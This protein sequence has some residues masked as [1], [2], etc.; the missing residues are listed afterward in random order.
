NRE[1][2]NEPE[3]SRPQNDPAGENP[4]YDPNPQGGSQPVR[5]SPEFGQTPGPG[6]PPE[7]ANEFANAGAYNPYR[8][9]PAPEPYLPVPDENRGKSVKAFTIAAWLIITALTVFLFSTTVYEQFNPTSSV[10]DASAGDL[11]QINLQG[12]MMV[13]QNALAPPAVLPP[14]LNTG[15][16]EARWCFSILQGEFVDP[17]SALDQLEE[18]D[19]LIRE[20]E[21]E[22]TDDQKRLRTLIGEVIESH[23]AGDFAA[24]YLA[25]DDQQFLKER[26]G[27]CGRLLLYP[28]G[29]E[30]TA[31][32]AQLVGEAQFALIVM[33]LVVLGG[34]A[35][36]IAGIIVSI[37][38]LVR[39]SSGT[40]YRFFE[41]P[42]SNGGVY[43][44][45]FA[46][47]MVIFICGQLGAALLLTDVV[48]EVGMMFVM[49]GVF[50]ASL[51]ALAW[52]VIR[53]IPFSR[54]R[55]DIGWEL[56]NP[57]VEAVLGAISY[58]S[59][60]P[61]M[62]VGLILA[63]VIMG[64]VAAA[65]GDGGGDLS[66]AGAQG[67]PIQEQIAQGNPL[68]FL[69]VFLTA[70]VAA[71]IVEETMFRGVL[72]RHMR[73]S[74]WKWG[75]GMTVMASAL[76]SSLIFAAI[77]PQGLFGI[78]ILT[79]LAF[80]FCLV[81]EWRDSLIGPMVMHAINNSIVTCLLFSIM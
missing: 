50:F 19:E 29:S 9:E 54:V 67:H 25:D 34:G 80:G 15:P 27:Y 77:H 21:Y 1:P 62:F 6:F 48:P 42:R 4:S 3:G 74:S 8:S 72:Y 37:V 63:V 28:E 41:A 33:M 39:I 30:D 64:F 7:E 26:L 22:L 14:E 16:P 59:M 81:R 68:L 2:F 45:T 12:K 23:D 71:P 52:P 5:P 46:I 17:E 56:K 20:Q 61:A 18:T 49:A 65:S 57:I 32:R 60:L 13:G 53:G 55:K 36:L 76:F 73:E 47:W 51:S 44:E 43:A 11:M 35:A 70:C 75:S 24:N 40:L 38:F 31:E 58:V 78:P 79:T 66:N 69:G 10:G